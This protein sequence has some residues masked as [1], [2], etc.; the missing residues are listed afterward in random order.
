MRN[1]ID[2]HRSTTA[3]MPTVPNNITSQFKHLRGA[4][5]NSP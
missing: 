3:L 2:P 5:V 1:L 4:A